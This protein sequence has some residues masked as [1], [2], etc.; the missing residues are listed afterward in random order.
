MC[1]YPPCNPRVR[2]RTS[3][4]ITVVKYVKPKYLTV[5]TYRHSDKLAIRLQCDMPIG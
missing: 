3:T 4:N 1:Y 5:E 2:V